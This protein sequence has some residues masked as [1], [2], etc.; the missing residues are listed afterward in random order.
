MSDARARQM[1][2]DALVQ[3]VHVT[4]QTINAIEN[5]K[6]DSSLALAF[7]LASVLD[8]RLTNYLFEVRAM[9]KTQKTIIGM[10]L[11]TTIELV[12]FLMICLNNAAMGT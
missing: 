10:T 3:Q 11:H 6:Y 9:S 1:S 12:L 4:R 2:Q 5:A 7:K 8:T